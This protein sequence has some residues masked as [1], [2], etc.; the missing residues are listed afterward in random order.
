MPAVV[1][2]DRGGEPHSPVDVLEG[3]GHTLGGVTLPAG[4]PPAA[5]WV[6]ASGA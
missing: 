2:E 5:P 6:H 3:L 4:Q 1:A